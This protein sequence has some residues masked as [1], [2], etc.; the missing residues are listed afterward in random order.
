MLCCSGSKS[1]KLQYTLTLKKAD[2]VMPTGKSSKGSFLR[3]AVLLPSY[4]N[5]PLDPLPPLLFRKFSRKW[6]ADEA[7][8]QC[9]LITCLTVLISLVHTAGTGPRH[10]SAF[11]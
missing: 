6:L 10:L 2:G 5:Y 9:F 7:G 11:T 4:T 1:S 3:Q 8:C